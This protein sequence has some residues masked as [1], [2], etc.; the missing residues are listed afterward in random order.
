M[1]LA[2]FVVHLLFVDQDERQVFAYIYLALA[3]FLAVFDRHR[4]LLLLGA[5]AP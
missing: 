1:L 5:K 4:V 2:L 3:G